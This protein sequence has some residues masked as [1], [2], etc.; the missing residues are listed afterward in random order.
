MVTKR[1]AAVLFVVMADLSIL[2]S[3]TA[4]RPPLSTAE[5]DAITTLLRLEDT[6]TLDEAALARLLKAGHPEVRRRAAMAVG[7]INKPEGAS[8]LMPVRADADV[9]VAGAVVFAA[10]Q[11]KDSGA[12]SWLGGVLSSPKAPASVRR[13]A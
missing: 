10:G 8:L 7:R 13:E 5:V 6:R 2:S 1:I 3:Q 11:L 12:V 4:A 9:E